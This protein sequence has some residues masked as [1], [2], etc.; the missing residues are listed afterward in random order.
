MWTISKKKKKKTLLN[1]LQ[2][3]FYFMFGFWGPE[4]RGSLAR[5][6]RMEP[7]LPA[8]EGELLATDAQGSPSD[9]NFY[10]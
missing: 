10:S 8:S 3:C 6:S 1:L 9:F 7:L 4:G 5:Q 2:Y